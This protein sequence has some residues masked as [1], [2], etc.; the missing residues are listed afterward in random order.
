ME[1]TIPNCF[2][3]QEIINFIDLWID[4]GYEVYYKLDIGLKEKLTSLCIKQLGDDAYSC[5]I[6]PNDFTQTLHHLRKYI[7]SGQREYALDLAETMRKNA[8]E[9]FDNV[10][11]ELYE[12]RLNER[13]SLI[14]YEL[15]L[16][17]RIDKIN[18]EISWGYTG[19]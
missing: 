2:Y 11:S 12:E 15:G 13:Q 8:V 9:Y 7:E 5:I 18:G 14:R 17:P 19:T 6:E 4:E 16:V 10:L 1:R 3:N